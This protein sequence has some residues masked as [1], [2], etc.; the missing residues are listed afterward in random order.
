MESNLI[1]LNE[2]T[3][4]LSCL[5]E[6]KLN[7]DLYIILH[8]KFYNNYELPKLIKDLFEDEKEQLLKYLQSIGMVKIL[9]NNNF[10]LRSK[11][12]SLFVSDDPE[13]NW[14]EFLSKFPIKVPNRNGG[15]RALKIANPNSKGNIN[16]KKNI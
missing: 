3:I 8:N 2:V 9:E 15:T 14:L 5:N 4:N 7:S 1:L 6:N 16:I 12:I 11:A 10:S 13:Q